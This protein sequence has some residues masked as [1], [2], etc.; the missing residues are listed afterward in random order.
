MKSSVKLLSLL[1]KI[2]YQAIPLSKLSSK[3]TGS[4]PKL[5][6][7]LSVS[8][9]INVPKLQ[10]QLPKIEEDEPQVQQNVW[11]QLLSESSEF[12]IESTNMAQVFAKFNSN[13]NDFLP[14]TNM[15]RQNINGLEFKSKRLDD[16]LILASSHQAVLDNILNKQMQIIVE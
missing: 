8:Q 14:L 7:C 10:L 15:I 3:L 1:R 9:E 5:R 2:S 13:Y 11:N 6:S 12:E 4:Q 16:L